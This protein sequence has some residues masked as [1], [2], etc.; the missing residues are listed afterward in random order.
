[1]L[2]WKFKLWLSHSFSASAVEIQLRRLQLLYVT[3]A[4][5]P[6]SHL[7]WVLHYVKPRRSRD[8]LLLK[9]WW[10]QWS[11]PCRRYCVALTIYLPWF[12]PSWKAMMWFTLCKHLLLND[13][14]FE[15]SKNLSSFHKNYKNLNIWNYNTKCVLKFFSSFFNVQ[16]LPVFENW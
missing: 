16:T 11:S 3:H 8:S 10:K 12:C 5:L 14:S 13:F 2:K 6:Y 9:R 7:S 4:L 15:K 1:M